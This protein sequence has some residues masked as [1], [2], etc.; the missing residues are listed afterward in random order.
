MS[1][2]Q[3]MVA[4]SQWC[5][6]LQSMG[7][8]IIACTMS[9]VSTPCAMSIITEDRGELNIMSTKMKGR[10]E[11]EIGRDV[12]EKDNEVYDSRYTFS[13]TPLDTHKYTRK[14]YVP[15]VCTLCRHHYVSL[16]RDQWAHV[17]FYWGEIQSKLGCYGPVLIEFRNRAS[18]HASCT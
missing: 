15:P 5:R 2:L 11:A 3:S 13:L 4:V 18:I 9:T 1:V 14:E 6:T 17:A 16:G 7:T 10:T 8:V 12:E